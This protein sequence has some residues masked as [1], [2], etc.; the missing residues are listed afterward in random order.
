M[1]GHTEAQ[2]QVA[3]FLSMALQIP[4]YSQVTNKQGSINNRNVGYFYKN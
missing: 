2:V 4:L 3:E 1:L